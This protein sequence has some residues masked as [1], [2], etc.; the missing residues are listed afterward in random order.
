M[1]FSNNPS[2]SADHKTIEDE[3]H[4]YTFAIDATRLGQGSE[5]TNELLKVG[6]DA[7]GNPI[8]TFKEGETLPTGVSPLAGAEFTLT[9]TGPNNAGTFELTAKS[10]GDGRIFFN[11]LEV[12]TYTLQETKAPEGYIKDSTSHSVVIAAE[13]NEDT[14]LKNYTITIDG[15]ATSTYTAT[16][17]ANVTTYEAPAGGNDTFPINNKKGTE[18]P[19]TG[20]IGTT[21]FYILGA[22]LVV[23]CGIVLIARRRMQ[24]N[25]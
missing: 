18:L 4:H 22:L 16:T 6:V 13:Y 2:N 20:G 10:D 21:I 1:K 23:G 12:G 24:A 5:K 15:T 11:N 25:S 3:T 8:T 14:T 17:N 7:D 19:S 9:G